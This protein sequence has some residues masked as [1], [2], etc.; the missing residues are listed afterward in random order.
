VTGGGLSTRVH[1]Y[2]NGCAERGG[3]GCAKRRRRRCRPSSR[4]SDTADRAAPPA[5]EGLV[6]VNSPLTIACQNAKVLFLKS[7][8][9]SPP[10]DVGVIMNTSTKF[11]ILPGPLK[12][13]AF[14]HLPVCQKI[15]L[16]LPAGVL[17]RTCLFELCRIS[18]FPHA[19]ATAVVQ[20]EFCLHRG[21]CCGRIID[22]C[23]NGSLPNRVENECL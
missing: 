11:L 5:P 18:S 7:H 1:N 15:L 17:R 3:P 6:G 23:D 13:R 16:E 14:A 22:L 9:V 20:N 2:G 10:A 4:R 21:H 8:A 12:E 19:G